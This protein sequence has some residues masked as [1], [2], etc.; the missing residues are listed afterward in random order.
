MVIRGSEEKNSDINEKNRIKNKNNGYAKFFCLYQFQY[1]FKGFGDPLSHF[2]RTLTLSFRTTSIDVFLDNFGFTHFLATYLLLFEIKTKFIKFC[3]KFQVK[4][5]KRLQSKYTSLQQ[6][7][8]SK[9][10]AFFQKF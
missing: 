8:T 5:A 2:G 6:T 9:M 4:P 3:T 10:A 1:Y 7:S